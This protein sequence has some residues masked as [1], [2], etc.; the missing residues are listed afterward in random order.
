MGRQSEI[1]PNPRWVCC[2]YPIKKRKEVDIDYPKTWRK[3]V[4]KQLSKN[5]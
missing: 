4:I 2:N 5:L 3:G 1:G